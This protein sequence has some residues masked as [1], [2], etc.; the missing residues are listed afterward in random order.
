M[1]VEYFLTGK[2][3]SIDRNINAKAM[4]AHGKKVTATLEAAEAAERKMAVI[5]RS[6]STTVTLAAVTREYMDNG[7]GKKKGKKGKKKEST[8]R[9][10]DVWAGLARFERKAAVEQPPNPPQRAAVPQPVIPPA[11]V[12]PPQRAAGPE[13][14]IP[15]AGV[16]VEQPL[17]P[18][19]GDPVTGGPPVHL[20][21]TWSEED[22]LRNWFGEVEGL[23]VDA[24][25][26][27]WRVLKKKQEEKMKGQAQPGG[28][29]PGAR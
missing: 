4:D 7:G 2:S 16:A 10:E 12:A 28:L 6:I 17:N 8:D 15:P 21:K 9:D 26:E 27:E 29:G 22:A 18:P 3:F 1:Q 5:L 25:I 24:K 20:P 19:S 14:V 11:R 13:P 23:N